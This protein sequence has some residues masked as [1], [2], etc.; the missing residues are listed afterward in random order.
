MHDNESGNTGATPATVA[1]Q[2]RPCT[3]CPWQREAPTGKFSLEEFERMRATVEQPE[4]GFTG[5]L[6]PIFACHM[7]PETADGRSVAC[8]GALAVCGR[9][10]HMV[11]LAV[12]FGRLPEEVLE[13][14]ADWPSLFDSFDAMVDANA[15]TE[16][17]A[18]PDAGA[19]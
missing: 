3:E 7:V 9:D 18:R 8:A 1:H 15:S 10:S 2:H 6:A 13:A 12:A 14:G 17:A 19:D 4:G 16:A 5:G 11:R